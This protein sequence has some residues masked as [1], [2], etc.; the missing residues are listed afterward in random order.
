MTMDMN[1]T[2]RASLS[3]PTSDSST[4]TSRSPPAKRSFDVAFLVAP[5]ERL[6]SKKRQQL[7]VVTASALLRRTAPPPSPPPMQPVGLY[8]QVPDRDV[9]SGAVI[10]SAFTKVAAASKYDLFQHSPASLSP[11]HVS[12]QGSMSPPVMAAPSSVSPSIP[13][14]SPFQTAPLHIPNHL[15]LKTTSSPPTPYSS[16]T[17]FLLHQSSATSPDIISGKLL[18][19]GG[20]NDYLLKTATPTQ[21]LYS[22][23]Y[24]TL[25]AAAAAGYPSF[26]DLLVGRSGTAA[27]VPQQ[28]PAPP[29]PPPA[30][31]LGVAAALLPPSLAALSLP[32]QNVCAKC[33]VSFR[34]TSDLVY[35]MRSHHKGD[36]QADALRRRRDQD[37]LRCPVC[38]ESFRERHHLT[39]HMTA[40]QDKEGDLVD[41]K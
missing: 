7:R 24:S 2:S 41:D 16:S 9:D 6:A 30:S 31:L 13:A 26:A 38:A 8:C 25:A 39:R 34:M 15:S 17:S 29:P 4:P 18:K 5:D 28:Q 21:R 11:D 14:A 35:H 23:P 1:V 3:S 27:G 12:Y 36:H 22:D 33:N 20:S 40:H 37:K 19:A 32:A 10:R